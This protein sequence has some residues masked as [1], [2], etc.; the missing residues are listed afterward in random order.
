[1]SV[2][3]AMKPVLPILLSVNG[4]YV[5]TAGFLALQGRFTARVTGNLVTA[6]AALAV[7]RRLSSPSSP[8]GASLRRR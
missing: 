2:G 1:M 6:G 3:H 8:C 4:A 7:R 5:G